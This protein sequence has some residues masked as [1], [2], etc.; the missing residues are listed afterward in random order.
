M[1][2]DAV[3]TLAVC[4]LTEQETEGWVLKAHFE[5]KIKSYSP[6]SQP[7]WLEIYSDCL[8]SQIASVLCP[9][10]TPAAALCLS[11]VLLLSFESNVAVRFV[12]AL[13]R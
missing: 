9:K 5:G 1:S 11:K 12:A 7:S 6:K 13:D 2:E 8:R 3:E 4:S 10:L